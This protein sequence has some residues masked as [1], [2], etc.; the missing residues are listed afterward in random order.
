MMHDQGGALSFSEGDAK[1]LARKAGRDKE[2]EVVEALLDWLNEEGSL[3]RLMPDL[4]GGIADGAGASCD[5]L[6]RLASRTGAAVADLDAAT[7]LLEHKVAAKYAD[8]LPENTESRDQAGAQE[9]RGPWPHFASCTNTYARL[10]AHRWNGHCLWGH[11]TSPPGS[12][13]PSSRNY[14]EPSSATTGRTPTAR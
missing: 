4:E 12:S 7:D 9:L 8:A 10:R 5:G 13:S 3:V 11:N 1:A 6:R 2:P 14:R